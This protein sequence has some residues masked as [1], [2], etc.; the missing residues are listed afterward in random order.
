MTD[1]MF[2]I[3]LGIVC[4][5]VS[6]YVLLMNYN[7]LPWKGKK[8]SKILKV[9]INIYVFIFISFGMGVVFFMLFH[10]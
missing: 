6:V 3:L 10:V 9:I 4:I 2:H 7:I 8:R 1:K 5:L